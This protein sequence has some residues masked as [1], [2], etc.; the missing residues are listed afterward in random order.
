MILQKEG[1]DKDG[2]EFRLHIVSREM[3]SRELALRFGKDCAW[4]LLGDASDYFLSKE[5]KVI[6]E[7]LEHEV[8]G[9]K[10]VAERLN[11]KEPTAKSTLWRMAKAGLLIND[12]GKY[13]TAGR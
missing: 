1:E 13:R 10:E 7:L 11:M 5:Q 12:N 2:K 4:T 9:P 3:E 8:L 6:L